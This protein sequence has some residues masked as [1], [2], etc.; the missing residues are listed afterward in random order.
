M[1]EDRSQVVEMQDPIIASKG[2]A[3]VGEFVCYDCITKV[4]EP[5]T[6]TQ[7]KFTTICPKC[8]EVIEVWF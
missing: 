7:R 2:K 5:P 8:G 1:F 3:K 6:T 4:Y